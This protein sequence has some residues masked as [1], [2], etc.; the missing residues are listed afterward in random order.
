MILYSKFYKATS[1]VQCLMRKQCTQ[2]P[3]CLTR[4][5]TKCEICYTYTRIRKEMCWMN[6]KHTLTHLASRNSS[7][8]F[9]MTSVW[10]RTCVRACAIGCDCF[11]VYHSLLMFC[12]KLSGESCQCRI[13]KK[14]TSKH[15]VYF[16]YPFDSGMS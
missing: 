12:I 10:V 8:S 4:R 15:F 9:H 3:H 1:N 14:K 6:C 2:I 11:V 16:F 13:W 7:I 5:N